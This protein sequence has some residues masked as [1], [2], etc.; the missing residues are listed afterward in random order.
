MFPVPPAE[1]IAPAEVN[2]AVDLNSFEAG[3]KQ[4]LTNVAPADVS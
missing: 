2:L 4:T 3:V 1:P